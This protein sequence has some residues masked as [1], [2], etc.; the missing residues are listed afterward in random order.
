MMS[1]LAIFISLSLSLSLS[2]SPSM[3][4]NYNVDNEEKLDTT[5]I[6]WAVFGH[7]VRITITG[8]SRNPS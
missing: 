3:N 2:L 8:V 4:I 6:A 1:I 7:T 5:K